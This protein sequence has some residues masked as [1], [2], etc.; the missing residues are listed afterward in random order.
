MIEQTILSNGVRVVT[1]RM[2]NVRSVALGV[3]VNAGS[4][5]ETGSE[6][7]VSHFIEHMLFKGTQTRSASDIAAEMDA[8]M[9]RIYMKY[10]Q[11]VSDVNC[12]ENPFTFDDFLKESG[13]TEEE[14]QV[15]ENFTI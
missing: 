6:L 9:N 2:E 10:N 3:W 8:L 12:F 15:D 7:G 1:E 4:V 14:L 11:A 5:F 13:L